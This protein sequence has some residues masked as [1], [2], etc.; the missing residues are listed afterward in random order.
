MARKWKCT[1][2]KK[3]FSICVLIFILLSASFCNGKVFSEET[4]ENYLQEIC[5]NVQKQNP[6]VKTVQKRSFFWSVFSCI[7]TESPYSVRIQENMYQK[8]LRIWTFFTQCTHF[9][10]LL[11]AISFH[12]VL[13]NKT[14]RI[15]NFFRLIFNESY[16]TNHFSIN[17]FINL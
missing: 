14:S 13:Y 1:C 3:K 7:R 4:R 10:G 5:K 16:K 15:N 11:S 2:R 8:K 6:C 17:F 12:F 9:Q